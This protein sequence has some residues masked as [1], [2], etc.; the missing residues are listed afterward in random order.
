M[1][2]LKLSFAI[3]AVCVVAAPVLADDAKQDRGADFRKQLVEKFDKDGD[4]KL[5]E[6]ERDAARADFEK[7]RKQRGGGQPLN[8]KEIL[9]KFDKNENGKI[10]P[11]ERTAVAE[12]IRKQQGQGQDR[13]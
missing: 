11:D 1:K 8:R 10:D 3:L 12:F 7:R 4:G 6:Q 13:R 5:N 9:K 2:T